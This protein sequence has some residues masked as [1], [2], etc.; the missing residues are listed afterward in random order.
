MRTKKNNLKTLISK[1]SKKIIQ[2]IQ[3]YLA[4]DMTLYAANAAFFLIITSIPLSML[5]FSAISLIPN[6][7]IEN[8][9]MYIKS[10]YPSLPYVDKIV[11]SIVHI[12]SGLASSNIISINIIIAM[13]AGST[14]F[15]CFVI[16]IRKVHDI[17]YR[18]NYIA[19][20]ALALLSMFVFFIAIIMLIF[21]FLLGTMILEYVKK[22]LPIAYYILDAILSYKYAVAFFVLLVLMLSLYTTSTNNERK[23]RHNILGATITTIL[24]L[25]ISNIFS[26]YFAMFPLNASV[27]GSVAG[28][29]VVLF[30]LYASMNII[31]L[32]AVINEV[33]YPEKRILEEERQRII[34]ELKN[35][36]TDIDKIIK[37]RFKLTRIPKISRPK[38]SKK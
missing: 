34:K 14:A 23:I 28:L 17:R 38:T 11:N 7:K 2:I 37:K 10:L 6:V 16:G 35:K 32:G 36:N 19:L 27:Y 5:I 12:A 33:Y 29:V 3:L 1:F 21:S 30:W 26:K 25:I 18:S 13:V 4:T 15:Y 20:R 9:I 22:Y 31:F 24:W 8:L